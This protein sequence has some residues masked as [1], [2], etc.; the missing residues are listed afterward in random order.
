MSEITKIGFRFNGGLSRKGQLNFYEAGR[1]Q[2][3]TARILYAIE[4]FRNTGQVVERIQGKVNADFRVGVPQEGSYLQEIMLYAAP[5][6]A[7]FQHVQSI[8]KIPFDKL[9]PFLLSKVIPSVSGSN[10]LAIIAEKQ[11]D[12]IVQLAASSQARE[13]TAQVMAVEETKRL[14]YIL[15]ILRTD[16][17][18]LR[19]NRKEAQEVAQTVA[20]YSKTPARL[21]DNDGSADF[22]ASELQ[23]ELSRDEIVL[24]SED[25]LNRL[26]PDG[27]Q[28]IVERMRKL[29]PE[30]GLPLHRSAEKLDIELDDIEAP[31]A[32]L[33]QIRIEQIAETKRDDDSIQ[34]DGNIIKLDKETGF[35]RFRPV[36]SRS[37]LSF[38]IPRDNFNAKRT[39]FISAFTSQHVTIQAFPYRDGIGNITRLSVVSIL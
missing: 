3:A 21:L 10:R 28:R 27:E 23:A 22:L 9:F 37:T 31:I 38:S 13:Q 35:G 33:N 7:D 32:S 29:F 11:I 6:V 8:I 34:L 2:Y 5:L 12:A 18:G 36:A 17:S 16:Q 30:V 14:R 25:E 26:S 24:Q 4:H 1:S 15:D 19:D 39:E 20:K